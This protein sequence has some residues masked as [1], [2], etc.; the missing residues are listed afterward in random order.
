[1]TSAVSGFYS[2][3]YL[4]RYIMLVLVLDL[5]GLLAT[6]TATTVR[7]DLSLLLRLFLLVGTHLVVTGRSFFTAYWLLDVVVFVIIVV[8]AQQVV[9]VV[10]LLVGLELGIAVDVSLRSAVLVFVLFLQSLIQLL[11]L[12]VLIH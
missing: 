12:F 9:V 10:L 8:V 2:I 1:M 4:L 7:Q 6:T 5:D 11:K 3:V